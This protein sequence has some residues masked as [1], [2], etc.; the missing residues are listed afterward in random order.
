M[1]RTFFRD[2]DLRRRKLGMSYAVLAKRSGVSMPTIVRTLSGANPDVSLS[3][4]QAIA[5]ALGA[6]IKIEPQVDVL[7]LR[8]KQAAQKAKQLVRMVQGTSAL[9]AQGLDEKTIEEM[10]RQ[11]AH[12]LL[13]G[14]PK[15]LWEE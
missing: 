11:M 4:L 2:L 9:E 6:S 15:R 14:S 7:E 8:E 1:Q 13:A 12:E 10:V 5:Q 3:N